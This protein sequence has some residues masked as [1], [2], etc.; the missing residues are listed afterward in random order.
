MM[1]MIK[2]AKIELTAFY[3]KDALFYVPKGYERDIE[4]LAQLM[5]ENERL[6]AECSG[7]TAR[8]IGYKD[9][10]RKMIDYTTYFVKKD[11]ET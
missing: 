11:N 4:R 9:V 2:D 7:D 5:I 10:F 6:E 3:D 1:D 8:Y